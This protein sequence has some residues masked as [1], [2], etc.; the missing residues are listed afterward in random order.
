MADERFNDDYDDA[1]QQ[2]LPPGMLF[3]SFMLVGG[4][5]MLCVAALFLTFFL[6]LVNG[7]QEIIELM[8][9][10]DQDKVQAVFEA[11]PQALIPRTVFVRMLLIN[12]V[13]TFGIGW[14]VGRLAR[15][16]KFQHV[17][18]FS[19]LIFITFM[20]QAINS[21]QAARWM[22]YTLMTV[23]G[24]A[25]LMG[26]KLGSGPGIRPELESST[27]GEPTDADNAGDDQ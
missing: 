18:F 17:F 2:R 5:Y 9:E 4:G 19:L 3:R 10:G 26:G 13:V 21:P 6:L 12:T 1:N 20:Q 22:F 27:G 14:V 25:A 24:A 23:L 7:H 11:D 8:N 15:F 16:S